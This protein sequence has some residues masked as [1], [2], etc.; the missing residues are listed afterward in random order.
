MQIEDKKKKRGKEGPWTN[1][2]ALE[3]G[4]TEGDG[5]RKARERSNQKT[6]LQKIREAVCQY[7]PLN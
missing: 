6:A 3:R 4:M 1:E 2:G 7:L 5:R